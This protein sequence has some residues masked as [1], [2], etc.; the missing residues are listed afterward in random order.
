[1]DGKQ[2]PS[3]KLPPQMD[4]QMESFVEPQMT[5][6]RSPVWRA[7]Q[8]VP[9]FV[10]RDSPMC[11]REGPQKPLEEPQTVRPTDGHWITHD[12][13][14]DPP[15]VLKA[16]IQGMAL[17]W[18][19]GEAHDVQLISPTQ[20]ATTIGGNRHVGTLGEDSKTL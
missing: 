11:A 20:I 15:L 19:T 16:I 5:P 1:M 3:L 2:K 9:T 4:P 6:T 7:A 12:T 14:H 10:T 17:I 18:D 8:Q 13:S